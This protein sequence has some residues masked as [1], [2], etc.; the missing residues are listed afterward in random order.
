MTQSPPLGAA[1][2]R[3][4]GA[5]TPLGDAEPTIL[6]DR[7]ERIVEV[8]PLAAKLFGTSRAALMGRQLSE[9]VPDLAAGRASTTVEARHADG[10][11][12]RLR[13]TVQPIADDERALVATVFGPPDP[14]PLTQE[15]HPFD[16]FHL[17]VLR[18]VALR[19]VIYANSRSTPF[20]GRPRR[21]MI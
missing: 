7:A 13:L 8:S 19:R 20:A 5:H 12:M 6:T 14:A 9:L 16:P 15:R 2:S 21:A 17:A 18:F 4:A 11:P 10:T 3:E 1:L